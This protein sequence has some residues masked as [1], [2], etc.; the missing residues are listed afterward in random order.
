MLAELA[1]PTD[2]AIAPM[3]RRSLALIRTVLRSAAAPLVEDRTLH[4]NPVRRARRRRGEP[5]DEEPPMWSEDEARRFLTAAAPSPNAVMW[6]LAIKLGLRPGELRGLEPID[7]DLSAHQLTVRLSDDGP[8]KGRRKRSL[9]LDHDDVAMLRRHLA[10]RPQLRGKL[11]QTDRGGRIPPERFRAEFYAIR[12]SSG[13]TPLRKPHDTRHVSASLML[14]NGYPLPLVAQ[15]L[16]HSS[17]AITAAIYAHVVPH[18]PLERPQT[19]REVL[20]FDRPP[21]PRSNVGSSV[22]RPPVQIETAKA[23]LTVRYRSPSPRRRRKRV[24]GQATQAG[25]GHSGHRQA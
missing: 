10:A 3:L 22:V 21:T 18:K 2:E 8:T 5:I 19:M 23:A 11:F 9:E 15:I 24:A 7:I 4:Q 14:A 25:E 6:W 12:T 16:G 1:K 13:V 17:P 20:R